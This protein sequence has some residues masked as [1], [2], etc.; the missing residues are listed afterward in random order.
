MGQLVKDE[1]RQLG[2]RIVD[3]GAQNRIGEPTQGREGRSTPDIGLQALPPQLARKPLRLFGREVP[4]IGDTP[5]D[6]KAPLDRLRR[7]LLGSDNGPDR[8][9]PFEIDIAAVAAAEGKSQLAAG[10]LTDIEDQLEPWMPRPPFI[11]CE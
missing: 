6:E 2:L 4:S 9:G 8:I 3:K 5:G 11:E 7:E 1:A 10:K